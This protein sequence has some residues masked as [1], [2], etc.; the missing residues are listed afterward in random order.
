[1]SDG[2]YFSTT[3]R[4]EIHELKEEL[5]S[6]DRPK[7]KD[8][9][10]KVIAAMTVGK[11]VSMLFPDVVNCMQTDDLELKK[12]VYLYLINYAKTQPDLAI[13]AVNTFVKDSQDPNPLIRALAVRTMGCIRVDKITEYLCDPLQR[14]LKDDDPYVRK[15]AAVC[16]AKLY[17]INPELVEDRG[18]LDM[19]REMLSDAN[20]MVVANALAAL[21]EIQELAG[22][23]KDLLQMN[24]Q[25]LNKL[26]AALNECT[27]WGQVFFCKYNDP[28]YVKMEK[29][30]IMIRLAS[31]KNIDQVLLELKEYAQEVDVDFVRKSVRA[32]GRCAVA[33]DKATERC[34]NVL[35][36]LIQTKVSYVVQEAIIVI[37]DIFRRYPNQYESII[38]T[39]CDNLDSLDEPEAKSSMI[40]I[41]GEY[42]ERID[43]ADELMAAFLETF[44]E[45]SSMVQLQL[46]TATVKLFLKKPT[47]AAQKMISAVLSC[48]TNE[49]DSPDLRDR[50]FIYW[51]LLS[52]DPEAAKDV[53]LAEKPVIADDSSSLDPSLLEQLVT[54]YLATVAAVYHR[55]PETFVSRQRLAVARAEEL[56]SRK[57]EEEDGAVAG[58]LVS[59]N[60]AAAAAGAAA[61]A[62]A[63]AVGDL[64]DLSEPSPAPAPHAA[65]AAAAAAPSAAR[66]LDDLLG[67]LDLGG[68]GAPPPAASTSAA[69]SSDPFASFG[70]APSGGAAAA[71]AAAAAAGISPAALSQLPVLLSTPGGVSVCGRL[72]RQAGQVEYLLALKNDT[73]AP[74][75]GLMI[76]T[77][78]NSFGLS[79][80]SQVLALP[81][82]GALPPGGVTVPVRVPLAADGSKVTPPPLGTGLQVALRTNQV[83]VL[84]FNDAVPLAALTEEGG[85]MEAADFLNAW[86]ALPPE[87]SARLPLA[88]PSAD[89][90]K[91]RLA[92]ANLYVLAHRQVPATGQDAIYAT[93]RIGA[94]GI[95]QVLLELKFVAGAGGVDVSV[96]AQRQ[97]VSQL[98][99]DGLPAVLLGTA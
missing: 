94:G 60:N 87:A 61:A 50:A 7:K 54:R 71:A 65:A 4:G 57:F 86:K 59:D 6:L 70:G 42:A 93:C 78:R 98:V 28:L 25:T 46:L 74:V 37:K 67:G 55:P 90:A 26:L 53:V 41:I 76:Q 11:D 99:F 89:V 34:I 97:D 29:L 52:T 10:K 21:Q 84:Y 95:G 39:L 22:P 48:A 49:T 88:V 9:V 43:N 75:D 66:G 20:P 17:D 33:L 47:E 32:I 69:A 73:A 81:A 40:W 68:S 72:V 23:G 14:C 51:R 30:E 15:T 77:N 12:L 38:A 18:F 62:S 92:A 96:K 16:V 36:E 5:R 24:S 19:L 45:E 85:T 3:K 35:L 91:Q 56:G 82:P 2:K 27:E 1:M 31:D 80:V 58:N 83:G 64:L 13:M 8:A 63:S 44:P 79:P